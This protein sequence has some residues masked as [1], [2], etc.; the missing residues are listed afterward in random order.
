MLAVVTAVATLFA[1][2]N[3][4]RVENAEL[5]DAI[6]LARHET[7]DQDRYFFS[8][9]GSQTQVVSL[10]GDF[11]VGLSPELLID[12]E[13]VTRRVTS[14]IAAHPILFNVDPAIPLSL[15]NTY[16]HSPDNARR[17]FHFHQRV[18]DVEFSD[19]ELAVVIWSSGRLRSINGPVRQLATP[20]LPVRTLDEVISVANALLIDQGEY[21]LSLDLLR[22]SQTYA[23][24]FIQ[25]YDGGALST[26]EFAI[27]PSA[28]PSWIVTVPD[29][30]IRIRD[31]DLSAYS[32]TS[33]LD[34]YTIKGCS[35]V[36]NDHS[37]FSNG[38]AQS[39]TVN[40]GTAAHGARC[41]ASES[42]GNCTWKLMDEP[43]GRFM[44]IAQVLDENSAENTF[45][46]PC[47]SSSI[48]FSSTSSDFLDQQNAFYY[49]E[50]SRTFLTQNAWNLVAPVYT[51]NTDAHLDD[52]GV[53]VS[54]WSDFWT[55]IRVNPA[56]S[57]RTDIIL[58]EMGHAA[59]WSYGNVS[60]QCNG[61]DEGRVIDDIL[62]DAFAMTVALSDTGG[63]NA[64]YP[65]LKSFPSPRPFKDFIGPDGVV[66]NASTSAG[67]CF[68]DTSIINH[69]KQAFL[70]AFWELILNYNCAQGSIDCTTQQLFGDAIWLSPNRMTDVI[71]ILTRSL[72]DALVDSPNNVVLDTI[73]NEMNDSWIS[74]SGTAAAARARAV[75]THHSL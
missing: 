74:S 47:S 71:D 14:F 17:V 69:P 26:I 2:T 65:T 18:G 12:S 60:D 29:Y 56:F 57:N 30:E 72:A 73:I 52:S 49:I 25:S 11:D 28:G 9:N 43:S 55:D 59:V 53:P 10:I 37:R 63:I 19:S 75:F 58:H 21:F 5:R 45:V 35:V 38:G 23:R 44:P 22:E 1:A 33:T 31:D 51:F 15:I 64:V 54:S 50:L 7:A 67:V 4:E 42:S 66:G 32:S 62:A 61:D 39:I 24:K 68:V 48:I 13:L 41:G 70:Q 36:H 20:S 3:L 40:N 16:T 27:D 6:E 34:N 46:S 8:V